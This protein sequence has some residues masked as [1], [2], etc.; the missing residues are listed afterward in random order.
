MPFD[1][2]PGANGFT[3]IFYVTCWPIIKG[4]LMNALEHFRRGD[5]QGMA[6]INKA[7]VSPLPKKAGAVDIKDYRPISLVSGP[8]KIFNKTP[9]SRL[10]DDLPKLMGHHQSAFVRGRSLHDNFM[11]VQCMARRVHALKYPQS[12]LSWTSPKLLI[13]YNGHLSW[14]FRGSLVFVKNGSLGFLRCW[15]PDPRE[16]WSMVLREN[17]T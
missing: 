14:R 6:T 12:C 7:I 2:A 1:K 13:H 4:D 17:Q 9:A 5:V 3:D 16:S 11:L 10:A 15:L 8:I